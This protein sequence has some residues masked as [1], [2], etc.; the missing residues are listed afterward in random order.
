[1]SSLVIDDE[2][3]IF[4]HNIYLYIDSLVQVVDNNSW[5]HDQTNASSGAMNHF[6]GLQWGSVGGASGVLQHDITFDLP[7]KNCMK[8]DYHRIYQ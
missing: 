4:A 3:S 5:P 8:T 7:I 6:A 2:G 1:M